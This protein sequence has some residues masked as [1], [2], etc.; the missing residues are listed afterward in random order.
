VSCEHCGCTFGYL[1]ARKAQGAGSSLL[2]LDNEGAAERARNAATKSLDRALK[3]VNDPAPCPRCVKYQ[4]KMARAL[5]RGFLFKGIG[6]GLAAG[7]LWFL[8]TLFSWDSAEQT[9]WQT[10]SRGAPL[11]LGVVAIGGVLW[12]IIRAARLDPDA[13][14][15]EHMPPKS[16]YCELTSEQFREIQLTGYV[17]T[18]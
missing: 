3:K 5:W 12:G 6:I 13:H 17:L 8:W 4:A 15:Q 9:F 14:A 10:G 2:W 1:A 7:F 11:V 16:N 18:G